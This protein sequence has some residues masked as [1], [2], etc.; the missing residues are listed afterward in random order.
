MNKSIA[1]ILAASIPLTLAAC[2]KKKEEDRG[3]GAAAKPA[4][5]DKAAPAAEAK[6]EWKKLDNMK[7][8]IEAP[9][10]A[11]VEENKQDDWFEFLMDEK[12]NFYFMEVNTRV[13][14][15]H[16]VTE[17]ITGID[18]VREQLRIAGGRPLSFRQDD[19]VLSGHA[20]ECRINAEVPE[21]GFR[22]SPGRLD[23]WVAPQSSYVRVDTHCFPGYLVPPYY[24]SLLAKVIAW[25]EDRDAAIRRMAH[26]LAHLRVEG[27]S[28]TAPFHQAVIG[29]PDFRA[30]RVNT[31]WVEDVFIPAWT[32]A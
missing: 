30:R 6:L 28:T 8:Q 18:I 26:A 12:G 27:V 10:D 15:E 7:L 13:Q 4:A 5:G 11:K 14:V 1:L 9:S 23:R 2:G 24:D 31:R 21:E 32:A 19:V 16:P 3:G 17:M 20:I 25:G 29:H 22:P